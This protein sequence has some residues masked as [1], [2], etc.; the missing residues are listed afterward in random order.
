[1][2]MKPVCIASVLLFAAPALAQTGPE[3]MPPQP[4]PAPEI[5]ET[6]PPPAAKK[7]VP[8]SVVY[9]GGTIIRSDDETFELKIG[10]RMQTRYEF[11]QVLDDN[12]ATEATQR[13]LVPRTRLNLDGYAFTKDIRFK[14][15]AALADNGN[16]RLRDFYLDVGFFGGKVIFRAGQFKRPFNRQEIVSDFATEMP[17]KALTNN[18]AAGSRDLGFGFHNGIEKSPDGL[19]W[20]IGLFNGQGDGAAPR[21]TCTTMGTN[22]TCT[23][24]PPSNVPADWQPQLVGRIGFNMGGIKGYSE[25]DLEGGPLRLAVGASYKLMNIEDRANTDI[26]HALEG[27]LIIKVAGLSAQ[28]A[29]FLQKIGDADAQFAGHGQLGYFITPKQFQVVGRFGMTP[30][31]LTA[32]GDQEYNMEIRG[33]LNWYFYGHSLKWSND[34]GIVKATTDGADAEL[35]ARL[36]AQL[37]F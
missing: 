29:V 27:D 8:M 1:M 14:V 19:E 36:Q 30:L 33:G 6:S 9:D 20:S 24:T 25:G 31:A 17:E 28:A 2:K 4:I 5:V 7:G 26:G 18:F 21:T 10:A 37:I 35:Q 34:I 13:F 3:G 15:E 32:A 11:S 16:P 22:V 12:D 23:T